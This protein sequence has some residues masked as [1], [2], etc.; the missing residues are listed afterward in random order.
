MAVL[1][2]DREEV[3][4]MHAD[5]QTGM[6]LQEVADKYYYA[7]GE[8]VGERFRREGL[9]IRQPHAM[10][11]HDYDMPR[12]IELRAQGMTYNQIGEVFDC[13]GAS[14]VHA[15]KRYNVP[16]VKLARR[17]RK[18]YQD[19]VKQARAM[20]EDYKAGM[21]IYDM[22][23]KYQCSD[24]LI[25]QRFKEAGLPKIPMKQRLKKRYYHFQ[26]TDEEI[27]EVYAEYQAGATIYELTQ[28]YNCLQDTLYKRFR[29]LHLRLKP[30]SARLR[31]TIKPEDVPHILELRA[32]GMPFTAIGNLY[33]VGAP[34]VART[35]NKYG[36]E[37]DD[38]R[39]KKRDADAGEHDKGNT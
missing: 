11:I 30:S 25:W 21:L 38:L 37:Y 19:K 31:C 22:K 4:R 33:G 14:I 13:S 6:S 26:F 32:Q 34:T 7:G 12:V 15:Y 35:L 8:T 2:Y 5:Y 23:T 24:T 27:R 9:P 28:K 1:V 3:R 10:K 17:S 20:Y 39:R 18:S 16:K 29:R 36:V